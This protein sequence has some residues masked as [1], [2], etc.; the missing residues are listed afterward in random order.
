MELRT[1]QARPAD[2]VR[3]AEIHVDASRAAFTGLLPKR[4][5]DTLC[6]RQMARRWAPLTLT[7]DGGFFVAEENEVVGFCLVTRARGELPDNHAA[8]IMAIYVDPE[9]Y[10]AGIGTRLMDIALDHASIRGF[11]EIM[12]WVLPG[13]ERTRRFYESFGFSSNGVEHTHHG[14]RTQTPH[15]EYRR[16]LLSMPTSE[17]FGHESA[18]ENECHLHPSDEI[19]GLRCSKIVPL[20]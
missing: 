12:L 6:P 4:E 19:P 8:E 2:T 11:T 18:K 15:L 14:L 17:P 5:L 16:P 20:A 10:S 9:R 3:I 7:H 13:N 1:R